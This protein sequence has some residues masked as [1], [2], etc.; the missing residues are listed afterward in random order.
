MVSALA[1][2]VY[3]DEIDPAESESIVTEDVPEEYGFD[4]MIRFEDLLRQ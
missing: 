1:I 2:P 4:Y 3:A